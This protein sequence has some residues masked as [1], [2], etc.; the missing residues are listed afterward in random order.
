MTFKTTLSTAVGVI[1]AI[2]IPITGGV[3]VAYAVNTVPADAIAP[4]LPSGDL[5]NHL[6][7]LVA[8]DSH[9]DALHV[10]DEEN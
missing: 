4:S 3:G 8:A 7:T 10:L 9:A 2:A 6:K 1:A 5:E